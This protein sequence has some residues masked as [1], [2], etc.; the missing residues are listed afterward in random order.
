V[1]RSEADEA[2]PIAARQT[3]VSIDDILVVIPAL[4]EA[5]S[6]ASVIDR[7]R[8]QG[9]Q[10]IRVVD[11]GSADGTIA[12]AQHAGVEVLAEPV[13]GYGM[14]CWRG[15]QDLPPDTAWI[16]FCDADG[17]D[18]IEALSQFVQRAQAGVLLVIGNR[19]AD[20]Q[21]R[22]N[23]TLPQRFG[24]RLATTLIRWIWGATYT[25][26]G[27]LRLVNRTLLD[28]IAMQDRGFGWTV[29]MQIRAAQLRAPSAEVA[30]AY[31]PR[32]HGKSK[33]SGTVR[34]VIMAGSI[35]LGTIAK[36]AWRDLHGRKAVNGASNRRETK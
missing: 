32:Q 2:L 7:L 20:P 34:G 12:V 22:R 30:V 1:T 14:A 15:L 11:N 29:E 10:S 9:I 27:P 8:K 36:H 6:I 3:A 35:I 17:C 16:L 21:S 19:L 24:N 33:I 18:D 25:D 13:R 31:H 23:L 5:A 4:N 26:L 28:Q